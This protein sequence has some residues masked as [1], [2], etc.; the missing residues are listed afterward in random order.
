MS[1]KKRKYQDYYLS[2]GFTYVIKDGLQVPQC[3]LCMKTF[4]KS[5]MKRGPL[6]QHLENAPPSMKV[7]NLSFFELKLS[8]LKKQKLDRTGFFF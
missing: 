6:K 8:N 4:S 2:F 1:Q 3:V 5:T 7:K